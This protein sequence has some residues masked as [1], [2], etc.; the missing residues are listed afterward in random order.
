MGPWDLGEKQSS[1]NASCLRERSGLKFHSHW[2]GPR[3]RGRGASVGANYIPPLLSLASTLCF[4]NWLSKNFKNCTNLLFLKF[5]IK[6]K[7]D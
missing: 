1:E 6:A 7:P 4:A 2:S 3:W 5:T